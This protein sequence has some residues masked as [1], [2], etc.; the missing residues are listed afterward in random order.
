MFCGKVVSPAITCDFVF[1]FPLFEAF[2]L[3]HRNM[4]YVHLKLRGKGDKT[5]EQTENWWNTANNL[6][7]E[8]CHPILWIVSE[9]IL[10]ILP[11]QYLC[12]IKQYLV[13]DSRG[14]GKFIKTLQRDKYMILLQQPFSQCYYS[15]GWCNNLIWLQVVKLCF[16]SGKSGNWFIK[17]MTYNALIH[18]LSGYKS[19]CC[20][21]W[22][23]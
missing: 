1:F 3:R 11:R 23:S 19:G 13:S 9:A 17:V 6:L 8:S 7:T 20:G 10:G 2:W 5:S 18:L 4:F 16:T 22:H 21:C 12:T 15:S 14:Q